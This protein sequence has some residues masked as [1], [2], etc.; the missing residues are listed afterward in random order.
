MSPKLAQAVARPNC[1]R[2][3]YPRRPSSN[4]SNNDS[5]R[6]QFDPD[7]TRFKNWPVAMIVREAE[8]C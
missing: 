4:W 2:S 3:R 8:R 7:L 5:Y 1:Y 6:Y